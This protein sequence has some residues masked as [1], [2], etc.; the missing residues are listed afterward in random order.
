[1]QEELINVVNQC[2]LIYLKLILKQSAQEI[3]IIVKFCFETIYTQKYKHLA[4][5][6]ILL[7]LPKNLL[8]LSN[9]FLQ[10]INPSSSYK[11]L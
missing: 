10:Q 11:K 9:M 1:M 2:Y 6:C 8:T 7:K 3:L 5:N 4:E